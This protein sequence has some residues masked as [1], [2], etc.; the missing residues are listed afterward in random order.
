MVYINN[1]SLSIQNQDSGAIVGCG[2]QHVTIKHL[3]VVVASIHCKSHPVESISTPG[4][5]S[6]KSA[7]YSTPL[8]IKHLPNNFFSI[9]KKKKTGFV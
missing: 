7:S 5:K 6:N 9:Q 1:T 3:L 2:A 4:V 8:T